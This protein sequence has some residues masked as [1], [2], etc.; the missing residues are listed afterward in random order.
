MLNRYIVKVPIYIRLK[1]KKTT[2]L[3][4]NDLTAND[5]LSVSMTDWHSPKYSELCLK[6]ANDSQYFTNDRL[7]KEFSQK[8]P[9]NIVYPLSA[10]MDHVWPV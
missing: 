8:V 1:F 10:V 5:Y 9:K 4:Q 7:V 3:N 6:L 2:D